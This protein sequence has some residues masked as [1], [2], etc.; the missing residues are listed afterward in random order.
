MT[1]AEKLKLARQHKGK[2]SASASGNAT[3]ATEATKPPTLSPP[4]IVE[5]NLPG[6]PR[7]LPI[8]ITDEPLRV[9]PISK[10]AMDAGAEDLRREK[11]KAPME[12]EGDSSLQ[13]GVRRQK[14]MTWKPQWKVRDDA[15][16]FGDLEEFPLGLYHGFKLPTDEPRY[17]G[18]DLETLIV[19]QRQ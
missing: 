12:G 3:P 18:M 16:C 7:S 8:V 14:V 9:Q 10:V 19:L 5:E 6:P 17:K 11:R 2:A 1:P 4:H 15:S 13:S